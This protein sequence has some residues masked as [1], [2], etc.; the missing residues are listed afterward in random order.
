MAR[1]ARIDRDAV[2]DASLELADGGGVDAVTMQAVA[3]RL[4]VTPMALYRHVDNKRDLLDGVVERLLDEVPLPSPA[5]VW[6]QQ[7]VAMARSLRAVA[8]RH[9]AVFPLLLQLPA[10]T[11]ASR[12]ARDRVCELLERSGVD[13]VDVAQLERLVS[14]AVLGFAASEVSGRF[15]GQSRAQLDRDF[16]VLLDVLRA[17]IAARRA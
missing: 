12:R 9:P 6:D 4:G 16:D 17:G 14:T 11:A 5:L 8:R 13:G 1:P 2:L 3:D 7:L 15:E 10:T